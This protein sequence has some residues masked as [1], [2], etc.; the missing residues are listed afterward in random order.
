[1]IEEVGRYILCKIEMTECMQE[2]I[3]Q[4]CH[5]CKKYTGCEKYNNYVDAWIELQKAFL[6]ETG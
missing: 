4:V 3:L 5:I 6:K 1:M 2:K